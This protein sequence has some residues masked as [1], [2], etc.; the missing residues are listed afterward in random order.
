MNA[1]SDNNG[2]CFLLPGPEPSELDVLLLPTLIRFDAA[3]APLFRAGGGQLRVRDYP[4]LH[5]WLR[6]CWASRE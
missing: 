3:Y 1:S 6:A 4:R 5:A 2:D